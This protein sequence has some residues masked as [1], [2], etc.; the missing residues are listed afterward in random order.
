M[1]T[2]YRKVKE[3]QKPIPTLVRPVQNDGK[4]TYPY[5]DTTPP[6]D[7]SAAQSQPPADPS[8]GAPPESAGVPPESANVQPE[9]TSSQPEQPAQGGVPEE[10]SDFAATPFGFGANQRPGAY[11]S[12]YGGHQGMYGAPPGQYG[13][14]P[15]ALG[16]Y[17]G[18]PGGYTG[19]QHNVYPHTRHGTHQRHSGTY[20]S[21]KFNTGKTGINITID[22]LPLK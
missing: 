22:M 8:A 20:T 5:A 2:L 10:N 17:Q 11:Q 12:Q 18:I 6:P 7:N 21:F 3:H 1:C 16:G 9:S 19:T 15:G 14:Y 4:L 13:R